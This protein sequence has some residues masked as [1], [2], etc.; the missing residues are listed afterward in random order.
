MRTVT[1]NHNHPSE[2]DIVSYIETNDGRI[3]GY[4]LSE[5]FKEKGYHPYSTQLFVQVLMER[6][7]LC[8]DREYMVCVS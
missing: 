5:Y 1:S 2:T 8:F 4:E 3:G 7:V 6:G